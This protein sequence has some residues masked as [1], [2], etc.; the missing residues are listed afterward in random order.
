MFTTQSDWVRTPV[1]VVRGDDALASL[2]VGRVGVIKI[3]VE[4]S[5]LD[6]LRGLAGTLAEYRPSVLCEILPSYAPGRQRWSSRQP[7]VDALVTMMQGAG[8][9]LF[10]LL[11]DGDVTPLDAIE[12]H[13]DSTMTNY[14]FVQPEAV[15]ALTGGAL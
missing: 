2:E 8:Y 1:A 11:P 13:S 4:G 12:P 9:R 10:R 7:R 3:D 6:V 15:S 5:E 14:A